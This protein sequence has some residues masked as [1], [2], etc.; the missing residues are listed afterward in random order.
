M[1]AESNGQGN[2]FGERVAALEERIGPQLEQVRTTLE[3]W[4]Q[5]ALRVMRER[6]GTCLLCAVG[7][8]FLVGRLASR[9]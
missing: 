2:G 3:V 8:G 5:R 1:E 4:N 7:I 9:R 6:P